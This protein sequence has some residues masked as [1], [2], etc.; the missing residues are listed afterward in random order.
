MGPSEFKAY[1]RRRKAKTEGP[2]E[3]SDPGGLTRGQHITED[4]PAGRLLSL[5]LDVAEALADFWRMAHRL[6][7]EHEALRWPCKRRR[8]ALIIKKDTVLP[9]NRVKEEPE[10]ALSAVQKNRSGCTIGRD[11][12]TSDRDEIESLR[13]SKD[14]SLFESRAQSPSSPLPS[15]QGPFQTSGDMKSAFQRVLPLAPCL[16]TVKTEIEDMHC[17]RLAMGR[18]QMSI[19]LKAKAYKSIAFKAAVKMEPKREHDAGCSEELEVKSVPGA[20]NHEAAGP[21]SLIKAKSALNEKEKEARRLRRIQANRES[22]RQ[23]IRKKQVLCEDL[24]RKASTLALENESMRQKRGSLLQELITLKVH[25]HHLKQQLEVRSSG[26]S[27]QDSVEASPKM[28]SDSANIP[29]S[30]APSLSYAGMPPPA[31]IWAMAAAA[32]AAAAA[33]QAHTHTSQ[34]IWDPSFALQHQS[35]SFVLPSLPVCKQTSVPEIIEQTRERACS[36]DG[37]P[38]STELSQKERDSV[39]A[40]SSALEV[41]CGDSLRKA[42]LPCLEYANGDLS[43]KSS[44]DLSTQAGR[45]LLPQATAATKPEPNALPGIAASSKSKNCITGWKM[46]QGAASGYSYSGSVA[47]FLGRNPQTLVMKGYAAMVA[48][49]ARKRRK[50][51]TRSKFSRGRAMRAAAVS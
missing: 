34:E 4:D 7:Q 27:G 50:E 16:V 10:D 9:S 12:S 39:C 30:Q 23:T 51:L 1:A 37:S 22:A 45:C 49:E 13:C 25:N 35:G 3:N 40:K 47:G 15:L 41:Q 6:P 24:T 20:E 32:A 11:S 43:R 31:F 8:T 29:A 44:C 36:G 21:L 33:N 14:S 38:T 46:A 42:A 2:A 5:E 48:A 19:H 18:R 28:L 17:E 26:D